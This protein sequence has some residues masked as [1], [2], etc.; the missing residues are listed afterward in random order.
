MKKLI[1]ICLISFCTPLLLSAQQDYY[2]Q[3]VVWL[4]KGN[5]EAAK[6]FLEQAY[7]ENNQDAQ[8]AFAYARCLELLG[9]NNRAIFL[10]QKI[11][12]DKQETFGAYMRLGTLYESMQQ[13]ELAIDTYEAAYQEARNPDQKV[14]SKG[15][16]ISMLYKFR[17]LDEVL[18]KHVDEM[19]ELMPNAPP[20]LHAIAAKTYFG[21]GKYDLAEDEAMKAI[22]KAKPENIWYQVACL[23]YVRSRHAQQDYEGMQKYYDAITHET[24]KGHL[25]EFGHEYYYRLGYAYFYSYEFDLS[26]IYLKRALA[27]KP[28]YNAARVYLNHVENKGTD[29]SDAI[30]DTQQKIQK[31]HDEKKANDALDYENLTMMFLH[32]SQYDK[33]LAYAD[34]CLRLEPKNSE[35]K[36]LKA[37]T[38]AKMDEKPE[39][40]AL[41]KELIANAKSSEFE[42]RT[43]YYFQL[44]RLYTKSNQKAKALEAFR[45][46]EVG[47]FADAARREMSYLKGEKTRQEDLN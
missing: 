9:D 40:I 33:A 20:K 16:L 15:A 10:Y 36:Y 46:A 47:F 39:A 7:K 32:Q 38:Y 34:S 19:H 44:G 8:I 4:K 43:K 5:P 45:K 23:A 25:L 17:Q 31:R 24:L 21:V 26:R 29:K 1:M 30:K 37:I 41:L 3:G 22:N 14:Q 2:Q 6:V 13:V 28:E 42:S 27:I 12:Q 35:V 18:L 11:I